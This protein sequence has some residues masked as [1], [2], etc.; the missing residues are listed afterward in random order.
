M[1]FRDRSDA[2][3]QLAQRLSYLDLPDPLVLGLPRGGIPVAAEV[4]R[5][6]GA[7]LDVFV[8][9][10][11]GA[12]GHEEFGIG[13]VAEGSEELVLTDFAVLLGLDHAE[14]RALADRERVEVE[15]RVRFYRGERELPDIK[16][17]DIVLVDDGLATGV[18]AE[19][20][21]RSLRRRGPGRLILAAPVCA[22]DSAA[23]LRPFA[24]DVVCVT[25]P[26][27]LVA[28]GRWY[29][30]FRQTTDAEV[31]QHLS[32]QRAGARR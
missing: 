5:V 22:P 19:A 32:A 6:L 28:V 8:A 14:L 3:R 26:P 4:A 29:D 23:R 15:R 27:V 16:G 30:D 10:K 7:A 9:R 21:L 17:R 11:I 13:A 2:G 20:A 1:R 24:D 12:P 31:L 18:T 25:E